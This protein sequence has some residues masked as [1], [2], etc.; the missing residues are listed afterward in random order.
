[1]AAP[2]PKRA[3]TSKQSAPPLPPL[4]KAKTSVETLFSAPD[5]EVLNAE[6]ITHQSPAS[7]I[8]ELLRERMFDGI[9]EASDPRLLTLTGL[10]ASSIREQVTF[11][12]RTRE[13]LRD[14]I[15]EMLLM[16]NCP[17]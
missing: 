4:E 9:T 15:R 13:E 2:T 7:I 3:R 16:V 10:L 5:N 11:H 12:S 1:M 14:T 6:D 17:L 8:A